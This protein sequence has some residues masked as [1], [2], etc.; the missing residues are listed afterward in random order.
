MSAEK[1]TADAS[2]RPLAREAFDRR[3]RRDAA[4]ALPLAGIF[5]LTSPFLDVFAGPGTLV[6]VPLGLLY[7]FAAWA[8]LILAAGL[9][10]RRLRGDGADG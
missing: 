5:L 1:E 9:L 7:I 8:G 3:R 4:I 10:A 2:I 6:G